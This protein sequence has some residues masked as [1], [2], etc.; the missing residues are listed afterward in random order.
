MDEYRV[1]RPPCRRCGA[2]P[3]LPV[4]AYCA[5]CRQVLLAEQSARAAGN[6]EAAMQY[7]AT[8]PVTTP[9]P[10]L[11]RPP[12][13]C[14]YCGV[15]LWVDRSEGEWSCGS[16]GFHPG[17]SGVRSVPVEYYEEQAPPPKPPTVW[18]CNI[19][20]PGRGV[21]EREDGSQQCALCGTIRS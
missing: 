4:N 11:G 18:A 2:A 17:A 21:V 15:H 14:P 12:D 5:A 7:G 13:P 19:C 10:A 16:C 1:Q 9:P 8:R 20:G 6:Y 3:R